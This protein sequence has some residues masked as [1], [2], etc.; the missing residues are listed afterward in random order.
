MTPLSNGYSAKKV[1]SAKLSLR[2]KKDVGAVCLQSHP[3]IKSPSLPPLRCPH[4]VLPTLSLQ[5]STNPRP[6]LAQL[7][8]YSRPR[9]LSLWARLCYLKTHLF[10]QDK[11]R[12]LQLLMYSN[13][14]HHARINKACYRSKQFGGNIWKIYMGNIS[15]PEYCQISRIYSSQISWKFSA[16]IK[17]SSTG[18]NVDCD[19]VCIWG[20]GSLFTSYH[21]LASF[22]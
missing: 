19:R 11:A 8:E 5:I 10:L 14:H 3:Y 21:T 6:D 17:L 12:D 13:I 22:S 1:N 2:E 16:I 7:K 9:S 20:Q 18:G 4:P 15:V